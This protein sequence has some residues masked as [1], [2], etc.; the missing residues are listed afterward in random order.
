MRVHRPTES[1]APTKDFDI[2]CTSLLTD[3][4]DLVEDDVAGS[5]WMAMAIDASCMRAPITC[6]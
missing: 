4:F 6:A 2:M 3:W 5:G 1:D